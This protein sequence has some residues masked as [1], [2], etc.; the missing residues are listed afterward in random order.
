MRDSVIF[1]CTVVC[2]CAGVKSVHSYPVSGNL[3]SWFGFVYL[4][5]L[6][7][8]NEVGVFDVFLRTVQFDSFI[9]NKYF[10]TFSLTHVSVPFWEKR[11]CVLF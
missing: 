10:C 5:F 4:L 6:V 7:F 1:E 11:T 3:Q 8:N 9:P 2:A